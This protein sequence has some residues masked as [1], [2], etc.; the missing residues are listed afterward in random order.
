MNRSL[1]LALAVSLMPMAL[2]AADPPALPDYDKDPEG[3][4]KTL[5][6][7]LTG[8]KEGRV[9]LAGGKAALDLGD[10][11]SFLNDTKGRFLLESLWGNPADTSVL[12][13]VLPPSFNPFADSGTWVAVLTFDDSGHVSDSDAK[14]MNYASLLRQMKESTVA[15]N[16]ER[17][18]K[19][20]QTVEVVG[21]A[22]EPH[23]DSASKKLYW[24]KELAFEGNKNHTLNYDI[25]ILG[26]TGT[27]D[28]NVVAGMADLAAV[29]KATP[30]LLSRVDFLPGQA[31][32]DYKAG[33]DH[34]AEFGVAGLVLGGIAVKAGLL[35]VLLAALAA[36]W[37]F[38]LVGFGAVGAFLSRFFKNKRKEKAEAAKAEVEVEAEAAKI[39]VE[40]DAEDEA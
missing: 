10:G 17:K 34:L 31:Y 37:K 24:A 29:E 18:K 27:I 40:D 2:W 28:L 5:V 20:F 38:I 23:Y 35:K 26:R 6:E 9:E 11:Y 13:V 8:V 4:K 12:G 21:W 36:G 16:A 1:L 7:N 19:G 22:T 30:A 33:S 14:G 15:S 3:F 25:R 32:A 39:E